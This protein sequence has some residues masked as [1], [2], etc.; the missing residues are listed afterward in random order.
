MA[1]AD[2]M[3]CMRDAGEVIRSIAAGNAFWSEKI[4]PSGRVESVRDNEV[5][6]IFGGPSAPAAW[7]FEQ[8]PGHG[9]HP[10]FARGPRRPGFDPA[11]GRFTFGWTWVYQPARPFL[12][13]AAIEGLDDAAAKIMHVVDKYGH[14]LGYE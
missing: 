1:D 6:V 7:I 9:R 11:T 12:R 5:L 10:V 2:L 3:A 4:P 14:E 13:P 8:P